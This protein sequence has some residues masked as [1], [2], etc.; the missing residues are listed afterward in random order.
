M[1]LI[2]VKEDT[3]IIVELE[4]TKGELFYLKELTQ[5]CLTSKE[6]FGERHRKQIFTTCCK[7]IEQMDRIKETK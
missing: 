7:I 2:E 4:I 1:N 6:D 5:N 3:K